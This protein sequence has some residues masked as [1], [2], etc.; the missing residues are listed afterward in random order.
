MFELRT[1]EIDKLQIFLQYLKLYF[2]GVQRNFK[3]DKC[4][5]ILH[6]RRECKIFVTSN[7]LTTVLIYENKS[8]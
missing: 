6:Q 7:I 5:T 4:K 2:K 1:R 8:S 3:N